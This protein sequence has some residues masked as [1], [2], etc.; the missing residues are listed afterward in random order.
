MASTIPN[1][2]R[3]DADLN[4]DN[5][6]RYTTHDS[7]LPRVIRAGKSLRASNVTQEKT[8]DKNW[9]DFLSSS[10]LYPADFGN[11]SMV[12]ARAGR[13]RSATS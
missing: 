1:G 6:C 12:G 2:Y 13:D 8:I 5:E 3:L 11:E 4:A 10:I 7:M 9:L